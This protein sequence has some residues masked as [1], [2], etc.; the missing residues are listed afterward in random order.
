MTDDKQYT[1]IP[2]SP[3]AAKARRHLTRQAAE[4]TPEAEQELANLE[5]LEGLGRTNLT[6]RIGFLKER[7]AAAQELKV[8]PEAT[9]SEAVELERLRALPDSSITPGLRLKMGHLAETIDS[10]KYYTSR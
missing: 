3:A 1:P 5:H 8:T 6:T 10:R 4:W 7:R 9:D 2:G